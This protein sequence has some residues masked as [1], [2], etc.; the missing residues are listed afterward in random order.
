MSGALKPFEALRP[1]LV[2]GASGQVGGELATLLAPLGEVVAPTSVELNLA[3]P[4]SIRTVI[5]A[6]NP[7]WIVNAAA[8]TAVDKAETEP[9]AAFAINGTAPGVIGEEAKKI[10]AAVLHY[11]TDY[12]F[13]GEGEKPWV[14]TDAAGPLGVYGASKLAGEQALAASGAAHLIFR[15]SWVYGATGK[16]FLLTVLRVARERPQM[17]IVDDQYGAPTWARELAR[18]AATVLVEAPDAEAAQ[19]FEGVYHAAAAGVTTWFEFGELA[20]KLRQSA[21]PETKFAELIAIP[22][23]EYP[24]PVKRPANSRLDCTK[25]KETFGFEFLPWRQALGDVLREV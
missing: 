17:K 11:S 12:V 9:D 23:S 6:V 16:N 8:Y 22:T 19:A 2:T 18:M 25:L 5:R 13:S 24:T 1:I 14:E 20:L 7:R 4:E 15:T 21:E 10:G 3:E